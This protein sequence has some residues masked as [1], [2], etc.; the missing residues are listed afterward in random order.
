LRRACDQHLFRRVEPYPGERHRRG[1]GDALDRLPVSR[2]GVHGIDNRAVPIPHDEMSP[3]LHRCVDARRHFRRIAVRTKTLKRLDAAQAFAN[4]VAADDNRTRDGTDRGRKRH[5]QNGL[6]GARESSYGD[7]TRGRW[8][9]Q[10]L[11]HREI[12]TSKLLE[13]ADLPGVRLYECGGGA[14]LRSYCRPARQEQRHQRDPFQIVCLGQIPIPNRVCVPWQLASPQ[15]HEHEGEVIQ[16]VGAG[17][18]VIELDGVEQC[19]LTIQQHDVSKMEVAVTLAYQALLS[20]LIEERA[21][22][23]EFEARVVRR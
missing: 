13:L 8:M 20:S 19:G 6:T 9:Q 10:S 16:D 5:G 23:V 18:L 1:S 15:V 3:L 21:S 7:H 2:S 12:L 14:R 4:L 22:T 17:Y 11:R